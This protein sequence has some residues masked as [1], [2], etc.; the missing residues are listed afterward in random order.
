MKISVTELQDSSAVELFG[1]LHDPSD[2]VGPFFWLRVRG[3][4]GMCD[5]DAH[6][7][8]KQLIRLGEA[9]NKALGGS[10]EEKEED[11]DA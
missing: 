11:L 5:A 9:I 10:S 6:M 1:A 4:Q 7:S 3:R 8:R 2:R